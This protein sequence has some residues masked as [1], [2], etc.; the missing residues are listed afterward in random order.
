MPDVQISVTSSTDRLT[1]REQIEQV[2]AR[3]REKQEPVRI[4]LPFSMYDYTAA[5]GYEFLRDAT[6]NLQLPCDQTTPETIE[7]LIETLGKCIVAIASEGS[8]T[9][10]AKLERAL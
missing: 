8:E 4:R 6:W 10:M 2:I 9:V 1:Q 3:A 5:R 7:Q